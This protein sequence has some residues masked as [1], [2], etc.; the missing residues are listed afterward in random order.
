MPVDSSVFPGLSCTSFKVSGLILS[1]LI[2]FELILVWGGRNGSSFSFLHADILFAQQHL[3]KKL[4]F[5][6]GM[7]LAALSK[8]RWA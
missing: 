4:S 8:I 3:L 6:L 2:Y 1:S 5:L 7:F